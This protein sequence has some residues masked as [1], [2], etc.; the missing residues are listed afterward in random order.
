MNTIAD[1]IS[2]HSFFHG[3]G[4]ADLEFLAGCG[5]NVHFGPG[6]R[7][8]SE[9]D[10]ANTFYI[11]RSGRA[12]LGIFA[13]ERGDVVVDTVYGGDVLGWSWLFEPYV[14]HFDAD[15]VEP[16]SA[17]AFDAGC[18]RTKCEN[19]PRL[20]YRLAQG[21]ARVML[22]RLQS[23]RLRMLDVYGAVPVH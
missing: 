16:V 2:E 6:E 10:A 22:D 7:I 21:F 18:L 12:A 17:V 23:T 14:W 9:G 4:R 13:S 19:E 5:R 20:G 1:L 15:A 3:L 11:L 8:L